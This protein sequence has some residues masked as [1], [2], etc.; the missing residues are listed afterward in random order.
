MAVLRFKDYDLQYMIEQEGY[1]DEQGDWVE[2]SSEWSER[3]SC[4]IKPVSGNA[5]ITR[6]EDGVK[7]GYSYIV[8]LPKNAPKLKYGDHIRVVKDG[9][10]VFET[11]VKGFMR[12]QLQ[13]KVWA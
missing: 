11:E 7:V 10:I 3:I 4:D 8:Y 1:Y 5:N 2:G 13:C 12:Y 9:M 6:Y